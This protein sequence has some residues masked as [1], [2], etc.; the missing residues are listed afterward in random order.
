MGYP[1]NTWAGRRVLVTG[2]TGFLGGHAVRSLLAAGAEVVGLVRANP[3]RDAA[4]FR[5]KLFPRVTV[6][7]GRLED[8]ARVASAVALH[9]PDVVLH[10]AAP[11]VRLA[12]GD[13]PARWVETLFRAAGPRLPVV[14]PAENGENAAELAAAGERCGARFGIMELPRLFGGGDRTWTRLVPRVA[15]ALVEGRAVVPPTADELAAGY[16]QVTDG[17]AALL[18]LAGQV[19]DGGSRMARLPAAATGGRLYAAL[20]A[21]PTYVPGVADAAGWYRNFLVGRGR[22]TLALSRGAA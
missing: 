12:G 13:T 15:R 3:D 6:V 2:V 4:F 21:D 16:A 7:R 8:A 10:L 20:I 11:T 14:V 22:P 9:E 18:N 19:A 17:I 5:D 1:P